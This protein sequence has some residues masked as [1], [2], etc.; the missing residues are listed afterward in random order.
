MRRSFE[1]SFF[2][3]TLRNCNYYYYDLRS[4]NVDDIKI[5]EDTVVS[6][7]GINVSNDYLLSMFWPHGTQQS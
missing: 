2:V 4:E 1:F 5:T 3:L 6:L 7:H